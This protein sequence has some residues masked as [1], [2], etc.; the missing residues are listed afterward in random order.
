MKFKVLLVII[1]CSFANLANAE[2]VFF[3]NDR[4]SGLKS[5]IENLILLTDGQWGKL[6]TNPNDN[7]AASE[8]SWTMNLA[9][10][11]SS[12]YSVFCAKN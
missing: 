5:T 7:G 9:E 3:T 12:L 6:L 8:L 10:N 1:F 2:E 4:C 11:Y